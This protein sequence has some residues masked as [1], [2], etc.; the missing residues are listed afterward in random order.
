M[1]SNEID[2]YKIIMLKKGNCDFSLY[3]CNQTDCECPLFIFC[4]E[5]HDK[6]KGEQ[7]IKTRNILYKEAVQRY[8]KVNK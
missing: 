7:V 6:F 3:R 1:K 4:K 2:V 5:R 8:V